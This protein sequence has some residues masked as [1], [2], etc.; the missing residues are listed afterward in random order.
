M[1]C[2]S[3]FGLI[4]NISQSSTNNNRNVKCW[5]SKNFNNFI[6][7]E[8][9]LHSENFSIKTKFMGACGKRYVSSL[10]PNA[11]M[12][13]VE[14]ERD[15]EHDLLTSHLY[16]INTKWNETKRNSFNVIFFWNMSL[17]FRLHTLMFMCASNDGKLEGRVAER[18]SD[19]E[20]HFDSVFF[21]VVCRSFY[22]VFCSS[23]LPFQLA[24]KKLIN[25]NS[26]KFFYMSLYLSLSL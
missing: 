4:S 9:Y 12:Y 13:D 8:F 3:A 19:V 22:F 2:G 6:I 1:D 18:E 11:T 24:I 23:I 20:G 7:N 21:C 5:N 14:R 17:D 25:P 16:S 10:T 15:R 26:Y